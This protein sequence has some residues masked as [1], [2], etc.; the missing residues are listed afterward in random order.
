MAFASRFLTECERK[1]AI[2]EL[3]LLGVLWG[4][5]YFRYYVYGKKVNLLTDH[6]ALQPLLKRNRAHKQYSAR[7]TRW[8]D[9]LSHFDVNVQY[10]AGKNIP[11]TDYLSRHPIIHKHETETPLEG[12]ES[13]AEEEFVI[14]RI[15]GL[16]EFNRTNGSI[17]QHMR[18]QLPAENSDHSERRTQI[19]KQTNREHSIQTFS[20]KKIL[21]HQTIQTLNRK[22]RKCQS[23]IE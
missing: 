11:L 13:E 8:L 17:T 10:T 3:E 7:L 9:R 4:L 14:N 12:D 5:E 18:R 6:Q 15:Y 23:W 22:H 2:N 20:P 16:F 1:Y 21:T 19:R